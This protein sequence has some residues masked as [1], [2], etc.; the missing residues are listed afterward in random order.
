MSSDKRTVPVAG[1]HPASGSTISGYEIHI[2]STDG[3]DRQ[4]PW[5]NVEGMAEGATSANG[6]IAGT[7]V[8]GLF[9]G[10][11]FRGTYLSGLGAAVDQDYAHDLAVDQ[12]LDHLAQS[13]GRASGH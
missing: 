7:Y 4:Q 8:H 9:A 1:L 11:T 5:L 6:R 3:P 10:D 12:A 13:S 2:G